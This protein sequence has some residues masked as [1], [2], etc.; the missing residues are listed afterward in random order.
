MFYERLLRAISNTLRAQT[1]EDQTFHAC[2]Y[3]NE[4]QKLWEI[5]EVQG[6]P[7]DTSS[8]I[9][10]AKVLFNSFLLLHKRSRKGGSPGSYKCKAQETSNAQRGL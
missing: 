2:R 10:K 7:Q 1:D 6:E 8:R 5:T 9:S 3:E 4:E